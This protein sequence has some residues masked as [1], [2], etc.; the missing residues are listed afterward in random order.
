MNCRNPIAC[1]NLAEAEIPNALDVSRSELGSDYLSEK[2]FLET[3]NSSSAFCKVVTYSRQFAGFAICQIFGSD[4]VEK[5][6]HLPDSSE[7]DRFQNKERIGLFDSSAVIKEYQGLGLGTELLEA[8]IKEFES[9]NT[10]IICAMGWKSIDGSINV[11]GILKKAGFSPSIEIPGYWN[12]MV[13]SP[14]GHDCPVCGRPCK[15]SA[16]L[17]YRYMK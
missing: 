8:C 16:V 3:I 13:D 2:D 11:D 7:K 6:L 15:C 12:Q 9:R 10:Q 1:R 17:Y 4:L 5:M 14:G